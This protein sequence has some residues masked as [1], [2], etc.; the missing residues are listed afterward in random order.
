LRFQSVY[1]ARVGDA[2]QECFET[3]VRGKDILVMQYK[4]SKDLR[5]MV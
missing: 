4:L 1:D 5:Q 3:L 2:L